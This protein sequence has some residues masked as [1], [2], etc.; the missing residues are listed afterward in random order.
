LAYLVLARKYR[1]QTFSDVVGQAHVTRTLTNA[2]RAERVAHAI[3]FAGPRGTG[4]TTIA[5]I[6]AKSMNCEAGPTP[7]PCNDCRS[8]REI[9]AGHASDVLEIDGASNNGVDHI[10]D[11]RENIRY[12]P[13]HSRLKIYIIDEVHMLSTAAFNALLKTLEEPPAHVMF[14]FATT[15]PHKIPITILSRCQRHDLRRIE[16]GEVVNHMAELCRRETIAIAEESLSLIARETGGSMRDALSLLDHVMA[17]AEGEVDHKQVLDILG[18]VDR[19]VI[20]RLADAIL[21]R[22][23]PAALALI[24]EVY[25]H[26][27]NLKELYAALLEHFRNLLVVRMSRGA[28]DLVDA[29]DQERRRMAESVRQV[30]ETHLSQLLDVLFREEAAIRYSS[31]PRIALEIACFRMFQVRPSLPI[32]TLIERLDGLS[33]GVLTEAE[34]ERPEPLDLPPSPVRPEISGGGAAAGVDPNKGVARDGQGVQPGGS[35][36]GAPAPMALEETGRT[37]SDPPPTAVDSK[38][39]PGPAPAQTGQKESEP[40]PAAERTSAPDPGPPAS[41]AAAP[42]SAPSEALAAESGSAAG[43]SPETPEQPAPSPSPDPVRPEETAA[44]AASVGP[45]EEAERRSVSGHRQEVGYPAADSGD[46][47]RVSEDVPAAEAAPAVQAP[48]E[49]AAPS[50]D[51]GSNGPAPGESAE[52]GSSGAVPGPPGKSAEPE[53]APSAAPAGPNG[54]G[55]AILERAAAQASESISSVLRKCRVTSVSPGA[56]ELEVNASDFHMNR[57]KKQDRTLRQIFSDAVGSPVR[58]T[59]KKG[60]E[61][62]GPASNRAAEAN[63]RKEEALNHPLVSA[64]MEIFEGTLQEV[65]LLSE[66]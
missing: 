63:R 25:D 38:A 18:V 13:A 9:T 65:K 53:G 59:L 52:T 26:G 41:K 15:E 5:R 24:D 21:G 35:P 29:T 17:C 54:G 6:L 1:P 32:E 7:E 10:R 61:T 36:P 55:E 47:H 2:I 44:S 4:K 37:A 46:G 8:C 66:E 51:A 12:M 11:L 50:M 14:L 39:A 57:L 19:D 33:R 34:L 64:A 49:A 31:Q 48:S 23:I 27:H 40:A 42:V 30:S 28:A 45:G 3:L 56:L 22:D 60:A 20:F 16:T 58:V 62:G 43:S